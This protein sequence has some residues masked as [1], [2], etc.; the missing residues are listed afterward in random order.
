MGGC[1]LSII[2]GGCVL[3]IIIGG[4]V[5]SIIIG[6][7]LSIGGNR[8]PRRPPKRVASSIMGGNGIKSGP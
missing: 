8:P 6:G 7:S 1:V 5:L 3:S 2:I 4:C